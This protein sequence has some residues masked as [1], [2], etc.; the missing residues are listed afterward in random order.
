MKRIVGIYWHRL[1]SG[2]LLFVRLG[3][4]GAA[5]RLR[6]LAKSL[7]VYFIRPSNTAFFFKQLSRPWWFHQKTHYLADTADPMMSP[8]AAEHFGG[9]LSRPKIIEVIQYM[10]EH[11]AKFGHRLW[12][13]AEGPI[14]EGRSNCSR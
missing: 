9:S 5:K 2:I 13:W 4:E 11:S 3:R 7:L 12:Q 10:A 8:A 6:G 1:E 14:G